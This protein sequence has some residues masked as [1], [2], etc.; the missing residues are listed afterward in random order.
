MYLR[1]MKAFERRRHVPLVDEQGAVRF[2]DRGPIQH[3]EG[4]QEQTAAPIKLVERVGDRSGLDRGTRGVGGGGGRV[5]YVGRRQ[6]VSDIA[7]S[8]MFRQEELLE[9]PINLEKPFAVNA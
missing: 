3:V 1:L 9:Q 8:P 7:G 5:H 6:M 4:R 2:R